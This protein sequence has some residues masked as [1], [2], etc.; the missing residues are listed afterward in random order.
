ML[1]TTFSFGFTLLLVGALLLAVPS[2]SEAQRVVR[3]GGV[4]IAGPRIG[5]AGFRGAG[6]RGEFRRPF[7]YGGYYP[8]GGFYGS[9]PGNYG[10]NGIYGPTGIYSPYGVYGPFGGYGPY[11]YSSGDSGYYGS[12]GGDYFSGYQPYGA[13]ASANVLPQISG[14]N[15]VVYVHVPEVLADVDFD[16]V[17]TISTGKDRVF[18]TPELTPGQTY[19]YAV[20][21]S[22]T[23]GGVP[24]T[25]TRTVKVQAGQTS[26]VEF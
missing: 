12:Y 22:W 17:K 9:Y 10:P 11:S 20:T 21:A 23:Q 16:G 6:F 5:V 4:R 14:N 25:E 2:V 7:Y 19:T 1:R 13:S 3:G 15:A 24:R 8:Y 18:T 26:T